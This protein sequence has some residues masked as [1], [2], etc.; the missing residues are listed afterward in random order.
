M[1]EI[2]IDLTSALSVKSPICKPVS[3]TGISF[4]NIA[5]GA[6][7]LVPGLSAVYQKFSDDYA[8][9]NDSFFLFNQ[10]TPVMN[11]GRCRCHEKD[12]G[13]G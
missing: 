13:G 4:R 6:Q 3:Q 7:F 2:F 10:T 12:I 5:D 11:I 1:C 8:I 9:S